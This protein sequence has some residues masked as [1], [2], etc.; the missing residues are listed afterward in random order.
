M[1][2]IEAPSLKTLL[3]SRRLSVDEG[4]LL[5]KFLLTAAQYLLSLDLVHG[6]LKPENIL[7]ISDFAS[8]SFKLVDFGSVTPL[9]HY[10]TPRHSFYRPERFHGRIFDGLRF[11]DRRAFRRHPQIFHS[12]KS[13]V[14]KHPDS[15][16]SNVPPR[17]TDMPPKRAGCA[18]CPRTDR[19]KLLGAP[20]W[21]GA[22]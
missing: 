3:R 6:D 16:A 17:S 22:P 19:T 21:L 7:V 5:G 20:L 1:E 18:W 9:L 14:F 12:A 10:L 11:F 13:S 15:R 4:I 8:I 2:F